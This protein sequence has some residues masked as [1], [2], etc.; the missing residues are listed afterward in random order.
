MSSEILNLDLNNVE[1]PP[2]TFEGD[3]ELSGEGAIVNPPVTF[4]GDAGLSGEGAI[5]NP[6]VV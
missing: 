2:V 6:E 5:V 3:G 4:E 1:N